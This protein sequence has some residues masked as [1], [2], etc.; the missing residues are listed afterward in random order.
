MKIK[1]RSKT[2]KELGTM[3]IKQKILSTCMAFGFLVAGAA[4]SNAQDGGTLAKV[5]ESGEIVIGH[6]ESSVPFSYLDSSQNP[7]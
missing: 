7:V 4:S 5:Q 6:R 2:S 3:S 1:I